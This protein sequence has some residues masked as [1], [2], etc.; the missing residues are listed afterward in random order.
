[1]A[2]KKKSKKSF[3][4]GFLVLILIIAAALLFF[5]KAQAISQGSPQNSAEVEKNL[6]RTE[7]LAPETPVSSEEQDKTSAISLHYGEESF[8][9]LTDT[10]Q[11]PECG[12]KNRS[13]DHELRE[14]KYYSLC[15]RETYEQAEWSAECIKSSMLQ[16]NAARSNDFRPDEKISTG[17]AA[18][19][20]YKNSG[21]DRGHLVPAADM[22]FSADAMSETFYMAI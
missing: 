20:D 14:F 1:M 5:L 11:T 4:K 7:S 17:S 9:R 8:V 18:L 3:P 21:Y 12:L 6:P 22:S 2:K 10:L 13:A 15:Y 16:K 19:A